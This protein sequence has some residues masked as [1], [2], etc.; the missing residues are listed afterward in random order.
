MKFTYKI[1]NQ[2]SQIVEGEIDSKSR[3]DVIKEL[4]SKGFIIVSVETKKIKFNLEDLKNLSIFE[5]KI[6]G[7]DLVIATKQLAT[8]FSGGVNALRAFKLIASESANKALGKR[9]SLVADDIETGVPIHKA[10]AKHPDIFDAFYIALVRSGEETGKLKEVLEYLGEYQER[11][12][13]LVQ[14]TKKALTYPIFVICTFIGVM[15]IMT[16]FVIP[17]MVAL[18]L[19]QGQELPL[20]TQII[21]AI[22]DFLINYWYL[23]ILTLAIG[24]YYFRAFSKTPEGKAYLDV[25]KLKIPVIN[26]LYRK[27]F[28]SRFSDNINTMLA[29]GVPIVQTLQITADVVDNYVFKKIIDRVAEKVREGKALSLALSE[30][31]EIPNIMLQMTRIGEETGQ[32]GYMLSNI[33][34]FYKKEL[35]QSIDAALA[36]IE[37]IMI[38]VMGGAVGILMSSVMLPM[39]NIATGIK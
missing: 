28:L 36:L 29:S 10:M 1:F 5:E 12:F 39:Y 26:K 33:S 34:Q 37:P 4:Q 21:V 27:M 2:N 32:L 31:P 20:F 14:K 38:V 25:I 17:K 18:L 19:E 24:G 8:L 7:K 35:E 22:S 15:I 9:F 3:E 23:I 30:E 6:T 13:A 16:V 11:N